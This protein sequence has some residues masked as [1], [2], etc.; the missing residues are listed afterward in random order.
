M[1]CCVFGPGLVGSFLGAAAGSV[2]AIPGSSGAVRGTT[3]VLAGRRISWQPRLARLD[4]VAA[5]LAA[6]LPLLI[7]SRVHQTPWDVLPTAARAAQ[8]GLGQP[9][10]VVTCFFAIDRAADGALC[11]T[12]PS[13]RVVVG[14]ADHWWSPVFAAWR[15]HGLEVEVSADPRPAQWE[16]TVLNATVGPL[17]LATGLSMGAVWADEQL[18]RLVLDATAEGEDLA[19]ACGVACPA[20]MVARAQAFFSQVG[21][22]RPSLVADPGELPWVL[23]SLL[24]SARHR[25][26][27]VPHLQRI[28]DLVAAQRGRAAAEPG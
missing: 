24:A 3:I 17:C 4:Q 15:A 14:A 13:P 25:G 11:A 1:S 19:L 27:P 12:G 16:K 26:H 23:G 10:A 28:A 18:R 6:G 9:R 22:H 20:G 8:N 5:E 2:L 21:S 7:A